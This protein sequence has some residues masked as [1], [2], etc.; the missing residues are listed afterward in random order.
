MAT[1]HIFPPDV[2]PT[3]RV[4]TPGV[5]PQSEFQGLNGAVTTIQYGVKSVDCTL[6]MTF[7][8]I[9]DDTAWLIMDNYDKVMSGRDEQGNADYVDL[10]GQMKGIQ[11][12]DLA[13][14][15]AQD[16]IANPRP[17]LRWRY[18]EPPEFTSVFPGRTTVTVELR[19]YLEGATGA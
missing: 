1:A 5:Y 11:N 17:V 10:Q 3:S 6:K 19:G 4:F 2:V 13:R 8:N 18:A 14:A 12:Q 16:P 15:F 7:A 9:P